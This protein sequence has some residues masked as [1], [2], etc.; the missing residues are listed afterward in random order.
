MSRLDN[1]S[2]NALVER[3]KYLSLQL[4]E[5][6]TL[7]TVNS[8]I[9]IPI[10]AQW[11]GNWTGNSTYTELIP[12]RGVINFD[13]YANYKMYF[14][15]LMFT[16]SG[17]G[18]LRLHNN[19]DNVLFTNSEL[20]TSAIGESNAVLLRSPELVKPTG[21]KVLQIQGR[22]TGSTANN[23]NCMIGRVIFRV[24]N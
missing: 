24:S 8:E 13:A 19:T 7:Q 21:T 12:S 11:N 9:I 17:T 4:E 2:E 15:C 20:S 18:F 10:T 22:K 6:K 5:I 16:D 23:V 1:L 3:I 14:E